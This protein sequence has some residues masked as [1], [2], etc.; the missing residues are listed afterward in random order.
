MNTETNATAAAT[1][2][3]H[4]ATADFRIYA[5]CLASY[6]DGRLFGRWIDVDGKDGDEL[7]REIDD[8]LA[9]SP[10]PNVT[11]R[12]CNDC[13]DWQTVSD[14]SPA[15]DCRNCDGAD[16]GPITPSA[17][18]WAIHDHEGFDS[19]ITS[20]WPDL[21]EVAAIAEALDGDHGEGFYWLLHER[22][23]SATD[24][25]QRADEVNFFESDAS[26]QQRALE[27]YAEEMIEEIYSRELENLPDLLK[28]NID[29]EGIAR[30]LQASGDLDISRA[31]TGSGWLIITNPH[32]F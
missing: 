13:G 24:A 27:E 3:T 6:N 20:E 21:N 7:R 28:F 9:K 22:N 10:C 23:M 2:L 30:D 12:K 19:L 1:P 16:F 26:S 32:D 15:R 25:A 8:M 17:E 31:R 4:H 11:R 29:Y 18:E 14:Y 5:A